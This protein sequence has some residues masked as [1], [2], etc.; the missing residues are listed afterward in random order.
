MTDGE[1]LLY[2]TE[3]E[4]IINGGQR[5]PGHQRLRELGYIEEYPVSIWNWLITVTDAGRSVINYP[6]G[7]Q[8]M[9]A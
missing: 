6:A 3:R 4:R 2:Y 8:A 9:H 5:S 1:L 7:D